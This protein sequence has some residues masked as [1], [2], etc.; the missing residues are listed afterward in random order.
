LQVAV[1][2]PL[3][4]ATIPGFVNAPIHPPSLAG[5]LDDPY[6]EDRR[7][8]QE[9]FKKQEIKRFGTIR[10][11]SLLESSCT[12]QFFQLSLDYASVQQQF[13]RLHCPRTRQ[14]MEDALAQLEL[15]LVREG[16]YSGN[17]AV[18]E[19]MQKIKDFIKKS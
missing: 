16:T 9:T 10:L 19:T 15:F 12:R 6:T 2:F 4:I 14:T 13:S 17:A 1:C 7:Y 3:F 18:L 11:S 8:F 5:R